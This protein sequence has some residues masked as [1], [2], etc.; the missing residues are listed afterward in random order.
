[1]VE[2][3]CLELSLSTQTTLLGLSRSGLYYQAVLPSAEEV[4]LRHRIDEIYTRWPFFGSRRIEAVLGR[5]GRVVGRDR[6]RTAMREM[7]IQGIHPG[8]NLSKRALEHK[9]YPYLLRNITA[10]YPHHIWGIDITYIRMPHGWMYLVAVIDWYSRYV[11]SWVLDQTLEMPFVLDCVDRAFSTAFP[12]IFNS[13][14][15]SHF[16]SDSYLERLLSRN[17]LVSMDGKGR[18][19]DNIFTERLWRSIKYEEVYLNEY[20]T[21]RQARERIR[22]WF[23]FY[24]TKRPHQSLDYKTPWEILSEGGKSGPTE[25]GKK[26]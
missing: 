24:N 25:T 18:A 9:T 26:D 12:T 21:P 3:D 7:G 16:T 2:R 17:I 5:E 11:V 1:M 20:D 4:S 22:D 13:D 14:Q 6:V 23:R 19:I 15:G 10:Q 8:P